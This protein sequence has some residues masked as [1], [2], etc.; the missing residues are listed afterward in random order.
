MVSYGKWH[1][2]SDIQARVVL[3]VERRTTM[4]RLLGR[5]FAGSSISR[6]D[7]ER[8]SQYIAKYHD[9]TTAQRRELYAALAPSPP[10]VRTSTPA[11]TSDSVG[12][13][14]L[15]MLA[16]VFVMG[17]IGALVTNLSAISLIITGIAVSTALFVGII[18]A[19]ELKDTAKA[20]P[21]KKVASAKSPLRL[22]E[23]TKAENLPI[24][25]A[26]RMALN[27]ASF[28]FGNE[29]VRTCHEIDKQ[30]SLLGK[31]MQGQEKTAAHKAAVDLL[32][33]D[34]PK[35]VE[36]YQNVPEELRNTEYLGQ[37]PEAILEAGLRRIHARLEELINQLKQAPLDN[38]AIHGR[39]LE[40]QHSNG[41]DLT[42]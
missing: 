12:V 8:L 17:A 33:N 6:A 36:F 13:A 4:R 40:N 15:V 28:G 42:R 7:F 9:L 41:D 30:L 34:L 38:L 26:A 23:S 16:F 2:A 27:Q 18:I 39:F 32:E 10:P 25:L 29:A 31:L 24:T 3:D 1:T 35:L 21:A 5:K 37:T 11:V 22:P 14:A 19:G 20:P